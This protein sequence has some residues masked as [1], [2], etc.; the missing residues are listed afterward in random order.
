MPPG[1]Q[2]HGAVMGLSVDICSAVYKVVQ[3]KPDT[4][5]NAPRGNPG[6]DQP[7]KEASQ[8]LPTV[9]GK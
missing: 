9:V 3:E 6:G 8:S 7:I 2:I 5:S 4:D 1:G